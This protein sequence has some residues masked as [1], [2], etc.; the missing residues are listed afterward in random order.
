MDGARG[1]AGG[2]SAAIRE[3]GGDLFL[4]AQVLLDLVEEE[5]LHLLVLGIERL[6]LEGDLQVPGDERLL[7]TF[8]D[9]EVAR[10]LPGRRAGV[11][12]GLVGLTQALHGR[13]LL[14]GDIDSL[15]PRAR[16]RATKMLRNNNYGDN[17]FARNNPAA[18]NT[19]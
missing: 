4:V 19:P 17:G 5:L 7:A 11:E 2:G 13:D 1:R 3:R 12:R 16:R 9:S 8:R 18:N 15:S 10:A 14:R 6:D